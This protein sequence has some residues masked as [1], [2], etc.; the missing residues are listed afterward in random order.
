MPHHDSYALPV[1]LLTAQARILVIGS[2]DMA[3]GEQAQSHGEPG[4]PLPQGNRPSPQDRHWSPEDIIADPQGYLRDARARGDAMTAADAAEYVKRELDK[5]EAAYRAA[6]PTL[7]R[8]A[9]NVLVRLFR[10]SRSNL[11]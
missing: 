2:T 3:N 10:R 6:H 9:A 7:L 5:R 11:G 8:R 1:A 4:S